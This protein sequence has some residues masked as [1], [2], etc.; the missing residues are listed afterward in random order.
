[1]DAL[2]R[3]KWKCKELKRMRRLSFLLWDSQSSTN[4]HSNTGV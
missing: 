4:G 1:M 3:M 2:H